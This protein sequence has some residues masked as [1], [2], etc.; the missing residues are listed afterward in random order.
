MQLF[1]SK[2]RIFVSFCYTHNCTIESISANAIAKKSDPGGRQL[3]NIPVFPKDRFYFND[4]F[5]RKKE[6][7]TFASVSSHT[8]SP[9]TLPSSAITNWAGTGMPSIGSTR[10]KLS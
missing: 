9:A 3:R 10:S 6:G 7:F 4:Y 5:L 2:L 1:F 8:F